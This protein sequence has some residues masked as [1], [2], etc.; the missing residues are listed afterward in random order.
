MNFVV[1]NRRTARPKTA[2]R[3]EAPPPLEVI[4]R[5]PVEV[6]AS[7]GEKFIKPEKVAADQREMKHYR[8]LISEI[9]FSLQKEKHKLRQLQGCWQLWQSKYYWRHSVKLSES[10]DLLKFEAEEQPAI[11]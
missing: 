10:V 5:Y 6:W 7:S 1:S 11:P 4:L 2:G 9:T 3:M 8:K